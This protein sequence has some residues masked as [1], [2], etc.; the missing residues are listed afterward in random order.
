MAAVLVGRIETSGGIIPTLQVSTT[1]SDLSDRNSLS[2]TTGHTSNELVTDLGVVSVAQTVSSHVNLGHVLGV[3]F[4]GN[5]WS[6]VLRSSHLCGESKSLTNG[7]MREMDIGLG[8]V[9]NLTSIMLLDIVNGQS[10]VRDQGAL[11]NLQTPSVGG[12]G[13][14]QCRTSGTRSSQNNGHSWKSESEA[15]PL[16]QRSLYVIPKEVGL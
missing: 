16:T 14:K 9:D 15:I 8:R 6:S 10:V 13:L 2:L 11:V 1:K 7:Q 5:A 4:S 12:D 3:L